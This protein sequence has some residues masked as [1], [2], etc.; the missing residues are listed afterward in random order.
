MSG[1]LDMRYSV[2]I[3]IIILC[4]Y[5]ARRSTRGVIDEVTYRFDTFLPCH[6]NIM[7][8]VV[9]G[10]F[11]IFYYFLREQKCHFIRNF[12][13]NRCNFQLG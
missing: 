9:V 13:L 10:I 4:V 5:N 6:Y 8:V 3:I 11:Y 1:P 2:I 7:V 12:T